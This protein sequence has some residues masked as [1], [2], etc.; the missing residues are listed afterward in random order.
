MLWSSDNKLAYYTRR[1]CLH[2]ASHTEQIKTYALYVCTDAVNLARHSI[3]EQ[4]VH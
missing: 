1:L 3:H 4:K 2:T